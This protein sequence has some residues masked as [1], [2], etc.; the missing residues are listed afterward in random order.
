MA[1]YVDTGKYHFGRMI[2]SHMMAD[3]EAELHAMADRIEL[4]REWFQRGSTPHY[5]VSQS[6]RNLAIEEGAIILGPREVVDLIRK[7]RRMK[8]PA[9][10]GAP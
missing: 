4:K 3:T 6:K 10:Q 2:M 5:D 8:G 1:V 7:L 9:P